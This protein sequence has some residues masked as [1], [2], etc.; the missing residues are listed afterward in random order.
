VTD[1]TSLTGLLNAWH[2]G[3]ADAGERA[4]GLV[5]QELRRLA[6]RRLAAE[7]QGH[8]LQPTAL[9]N[10]A[11]MKLLAG[12][13]PKVVDRV[14]FFA[15]AATTMR[16]ILVDHAKSRRR[17]KR[18]GNRQQ[19]TLDEAAAVAEEAPEE[20]LALDAAIERL[21]ALEP[22]LARI[23]ELHYFA[24]LNY[25]EMATALDVSRT[26]VNRELRLAKAWLHKELAPT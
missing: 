2:S 21:A 10:E 15:L 23:V 5:Y 16:R 12:E 22:R 18:G 4:M 14:H 11:Y 25:E 17:Q 8:T 24:G 1:A 20:M 7:R 9:V 26:T 13:V 6:A 19:V 3:D